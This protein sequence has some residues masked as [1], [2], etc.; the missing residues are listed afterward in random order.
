MLLKIEYFYTDMYK[1]LMQP[2]LPR[3]IWREIFILLANDKKGLY[4]LDMRRVCTL[5]RDSIDQIAT[6]FDYNFKHALAALYFYKVH[7]F[8]D[9]AEFYGICRIGYFNRLS[10][11]ERDIRI[12]LTIY[13]DNKKVG[14]IKQIINYPLQRDGWYFNLLHYESCSATEK[15]FNVIKD[16]YTSYYT[17]Y[18]SYLTIIHVFKNKDFEQD[19]VLVYSDGLKYINITSNV[20]WYIADYASLPFSGSESTISQCRFLGKYNDLE[21]RYKH[22]LYNV[23]VNK[24]LA[25]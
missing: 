10:R 20:E 23:I 12:F 13:I 7:T 1:N 16:F 14:I 5:F 21:E 6:T 17:C 3:D 19:L 11:H 9:P 15:L 2:F 18:T 8:V 22:I 25:E 4:A 24:I